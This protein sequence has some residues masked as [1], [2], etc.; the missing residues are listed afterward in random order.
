MKR[1]LTFFLFLIPPLAASGQ[2]TQSQNVIRAGDKIVKQ[3]VSYIDPGD[4]GE[5]ILWDFSALKPINEEYV[6]EYMEPAL[7]NDSI[8]ILGRDTFPKTAISKGELIIG[9]EHYTAYYYRVADSRVTLLGFENPVT[10]MHYS[11]PPPVMEFPFSYKQTS[12][13]LFKANGAYSQQFPFESKGEVQINVDAYGRMILPSGDTLDHVVRV[14]NRTFLQTAPTDQ[15]TSEALTEMTIESYRWYVSGYRYPIFETIHT[16][17]DS[18]TENLEFFKTA[19]FYPP[20]EHLY[21]E[22]DVANQ[23]TI[24]EQDEQLIDQ[25]SDNSGNSR[26]EW[27][28][29]GTHWFC[30][31]YPIPVI[32]RL[33]IEYLLEKDNPVTISLYTM[34]GHLL[35]TISYQRRAA[36]YYQESMD[37]EHLS[38]GRYVCKLTFGTE[39]KSQIIIRK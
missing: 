28:L 36:G 34:T 29:Q 9:I 13:A 1:M 3:Q 19:F 2:I 37:C 25:K 14:K 22:D 4:P 35:R 26:K 15:S 24:D 11:V 33:N 39:N 16:L 10:L 12:T 27:P 7:V 32:N 31:F 21:L 30:R 18:T 17:N 38:A 6:L 23:A 8:Y 5:E 20:Q